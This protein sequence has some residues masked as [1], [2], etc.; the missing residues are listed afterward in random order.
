MGAV[1]MLGLVAILKNRKVFGISAIA[2]SSLLL[3]DLAV[4]GL[5]PFSG[6]SAIY[7]R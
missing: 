6:S 2:E 3:G 7:N 1:N 4:A 5:H